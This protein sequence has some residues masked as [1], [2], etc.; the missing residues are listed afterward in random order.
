MPSTRKY[1]AA[2]TS[3]L[4]LSSSLYGE[5]LKWGNLEGRFVFVGEIPELKPLIVTTDKDSI[6]PTVPDDSFV[7]NSKNKGIA[8]VIVF[9]LPNEDEK[10]H[11]HSSYDKS[12]DAKVELV[13]QKGRLSPHVL[14]LRTSQT[15]VEN[16]QDEIAYHIRIQSRHVH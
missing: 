5:E 14:L 4:M 16:N 11:I 15:M 9:L 6:G 8:N 1:I 13:M 3:F 2:L 10:L 12:A 7:V